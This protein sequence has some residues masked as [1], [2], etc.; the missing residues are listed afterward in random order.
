MSCGDE[1]C[2]RDE[3]QERGV[4][5]RGREDVIAVGGTRMQR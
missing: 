3:I 2:V 5:S 4:E 1:R